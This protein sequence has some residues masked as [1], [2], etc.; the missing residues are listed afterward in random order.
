MSP[1]VHKICSIFKFSEKKQWDTTKWSQKYNNQN[2]NFIIFVN[3]TNLSSLHF[4]FIYWGPT[5]YQGVFYGP[6]DIAGDNR[7]KSHCSWSLFSSTFRHTIRK[8]TVNFI[9]TR[10]GIAGKEGNECPM[11]V[12]A[13]MVMCVCV[14]VCVRFLKDC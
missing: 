12:L 11:M 7:S 5:V 6:G 2:E 14:C 1:T 10:D 8:Q 9:Y 4:I 13:V 3:S